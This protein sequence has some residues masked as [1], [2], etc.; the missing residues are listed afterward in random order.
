MLG[1][2]LNHGPEIHDLRMCTL[3]SRDL[4]CGVCPHLNVSWKTNMPLPELLRISE[5]PLDVMRTLC[6]G[7][8]NGCSSTFQLQ[9]TTQ[10]TDKIWGIYRKG[11]LGKPPSG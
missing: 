11:P 3:S 8:R 2:K 4:E 9:T 10:I 5:A 1:H 7:Q 6:G